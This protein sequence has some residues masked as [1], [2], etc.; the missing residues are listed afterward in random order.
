MKKIKKDDDNDDYVPSD[1][2]DIEDDGSYNPGD[3]STRNSGDYYP[4]DD[5]GNEP[6]FR[7]ALNGYDKFTGYHD[8]IEE[9]DPTDN[10]GAGIKNET[11][12]NTGVEIKNETQ[13]NS[14]NEDEDS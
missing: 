7:N 11:Q 9:E 3:V 12:K 13:N 2:E 6:L 1:E 4:S 5:E 10:T 14:K 8:T